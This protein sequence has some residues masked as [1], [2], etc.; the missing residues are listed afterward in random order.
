MFRSLK[1]KSFLFYKVGK[2]PQL[3]WQMMKVSM[4]E[5]KS[6]TKAERLPYGFLG[7]IKNKP[8]EL[9]DGTILCP[10]SIEKGNN[11][12]IHIESTNDEGKTWT[13]IPVDTINPVK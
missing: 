5:G 12:K 3:W 7:P 6:W 1:G 2:S 9:K 10:S 11:W 4:Y 13:Y 8:I